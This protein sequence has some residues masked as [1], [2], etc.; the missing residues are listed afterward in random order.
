MIRTDRLEL[1]PATCELMEAAIAGRGELTAALRVAVPETWPPEHLDY[2]AF[3][4][5]S[6]RLRESPDE[7]QWWL[8]FVVGKADRMLLGGA[9]YKGPPRDGA[10]EI[11]YGIVSNRR[12]SG[13]ASEAVRALVEHAFERA[14]VD[15]VIAET[16][17][18]HA[19]SIG[20]LERCG[21]CRTGPGSEPGVI[22]FEIRRSE[23]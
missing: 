17:T 19:P 12:R 4:F 5:T 15:R 14:D 18:D 22:R 8:H 21:F 1:V 6:D 23:S 3:S 11:G 2:R 7:S 13:F 16:L 20:V 9:G 10:V